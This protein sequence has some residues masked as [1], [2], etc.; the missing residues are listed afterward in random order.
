MNLKDEIIKISK[1]GAE[2]AKIG[3]ELHKE[4]SKQ[5]LAGYNEYEVGDMFYNV[6]FKTRYM[7]RSK[8]IR[9]DG[10]ITYKIVLVYIG[11]REN[12][13]RD[14]GEVNNGDLTKMFNSPYY[15]RGNP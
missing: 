4:L 10:Y 3:G 15:K 9:F 1:H 6:F 12:I 8:E 14:C 7:I 11:D 5:E 13:S 2:I